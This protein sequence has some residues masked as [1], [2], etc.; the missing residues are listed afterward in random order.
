MSREKS[1]TARGGASVSHVAAPER[2]Q[3]FWLRT[4]IWVG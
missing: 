4:T 3:S 2:G 1:T